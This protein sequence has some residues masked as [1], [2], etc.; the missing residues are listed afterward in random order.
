VDSG[1]LELK[2]YLLLSTTVDGVRNSTS[3][4]VWKSE[5]RSL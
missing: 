4:L 2:Q 1:P 3:F 5:R